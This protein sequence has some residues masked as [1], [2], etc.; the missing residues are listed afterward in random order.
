MKALQN[1][2]SNSSMHA[3]SKQQNVFGMGQRNLAQIWFASALSSSDLKTHLGS[4]VCR[5]KTQLENS[6]WVV[7]G[8]KLVLDSVSSTHL[9]RVEEEETHSSR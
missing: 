7:Y 6:P 9:D 3:G 2:M 5:L 4:I 1:N 8:D